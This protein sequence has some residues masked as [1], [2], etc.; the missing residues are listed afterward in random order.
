MK[1]IH[2]CVYV[3]VSTQKQ[4]TLDNFNI[5]TD[6]ATQLNRVTAKVDYTLFLLIRFH[7]YVLTKFWATERLS[8]SFF[9][10]RQWMNNSFCY[11]IFQVSGESQ[12]FNVVDDLSLEECKGFIFR[13]SKELKCLRSKYKNNMGKVIVTAD[14]M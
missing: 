9:L 1:V 13:W 10:S 3:F 2:A 5:I 8:L 12:S 7:S 11:L 14:L 4:N 6:L